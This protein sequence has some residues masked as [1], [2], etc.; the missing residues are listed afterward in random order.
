MKLP[1]MLFVLLVGGA[2]YSRLEAAVHIG[3]PPVDLGPHLHIKVADEARIELTW[4]AGKDAKGILKFNTADGPLIR[5]LS[6]RTERDTFITGGLTPA[7]SAT[8]GTRE[9]PPGRPPGMS[10]WNTFFD[11]P[12]KRPHEMHQGI[13]TPTAV[14]FENHGDDRI[15]VIFDGVSIG[16]FKGELWISVYA[17]SPLVQVEAVVSTQQDRVAFAYEAGLHGEGTDLAHLDTEGKWQHI[18]AGDLKDYETLAVKHRAVF[19]IHPGGTLALFPPPHQFFYPVD[20]TTNNRTVWRER[21]GFGIRQDTQGGGK[22]VPWVNAPPGTQQR[23]GFFLLMSS[24][25]PEAA[26]D[27][28]LRYTRGDS[29][30]ELPGSTTFTSHYHMAIAVAAMDRAAK[31][32]LPIIP[33]FVKMFKDMGVRMVHLGEFHGDGHPRDPGPL[34]LPEMR[35]MF[36]ECQRLSDDRLLMLPGEEAKDH[37]GIRRL[38]VHPGHWMCFFPKPVYWT[39]VRAEGQPF[40]EQIEGYGTVY[41]V[42]NKD[43]MM[44]LLNLEH[45]VA[46]SAHARIKASSWTPDIY[47]NEDFYKSE[48]WLGAAFKAMPADLSREKLGERC[49]NLLSDMANWGDKKYLPGEVDVF[50]L[51]HTHELYG[52]MNIN[53]LRLPKAPTYAEGW[54]SVLDVLRAGAFFTTT[55]EVLIREFKVNGHASGETLKL[56]ADDTAEITVDLDWTFPLNFAEVISGDGKEVFSE[57]LD[58]RNTAAFGRVTLKLNPALKD[59]KWVRVEVWD[60]ARNGAYTQPVWLE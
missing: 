10:L 5:N 20:I 34:R 57:R 45:G 24:G 39:M 38:N 54:Q 27:E 3:V 33:D 59:R 4:D 18:T 51:D 60:I 47:R 14:R 31:G 30:P 37:L 46:W 17:G 49:L 41:H 48:R 13:F 58:L 11:N 7:F 19:A 52:H 40:S 32:M 55:G 2:L 56:A 16:P 23:L 22:Y 26:M 36:D 15:S 29:F 21:K 8:V 25:L 9:Q 53:Y 50:K 43:D 42:G 35:S 6:L 44:Q 1:T 12:G 28:V